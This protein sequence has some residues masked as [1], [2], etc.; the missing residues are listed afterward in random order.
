MGQPLISIIIPCYNQAQYLDEC[1]QSVLD[2]TYQNW[3]CIIVNDGSPDH[4]EDVALRWVERDVRF[5]YFKKENGGLSS[6]R[7]F[8]IEKAAGEWILPL[9]SDDKIGNNYLKYSSDHFSKN[10]HIIYCCA[11]YFGIQQGT[12][13]IEEFVDKD[14]LLHNFLFCSS[15]FKK[16]SWK[17]INGYDEKMLEGYEDW[18]FWINMYSYFGHLQIFK[19]NYNGFYYRKKEISLLTEATQKHASKLQDYI[20]TKHIDLYKNNIFSFSEYQ[21]K[22]KRYLKQNKWLNDKVNSKRYKMLDNLLGFFK[23]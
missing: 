15:F 8:G 7:N 13:I 23:I 5:K 9:D 1:L 3:E 6:A 12:I 4:T 21:I 17:S 2:Q 16:Q 18:E 10:P 22:Y 11:E 14:L 19:I 20:F